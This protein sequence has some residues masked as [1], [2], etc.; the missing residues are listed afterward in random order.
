MHWFDLFFLSVVVAVVSVAAAAVTKSYRWVV[1]MPENQF[2]LF[3]FESK[4]AFVCD[5]KE[6]QK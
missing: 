4:T 2:M 1:S 6:Q 5:W 3:A